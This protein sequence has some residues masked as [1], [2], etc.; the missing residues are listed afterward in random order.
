MKL[1]LCLADAY[2]E[3]NLKMKLFRNDRVFFDINRIL[4][5]NNWLQHMVCLH[6]NCAFWWQMHKNGNNLMVTRQPTING[7]KSSWSFYRQLNKEQENPMKWTYFKDS[8][9][10][11]QMAFYILQMDAIFFFLRLFIRRLCMILGLNTF[12][13]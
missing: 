7:R 4:D 1:L 6:L 10:T 11:F 9:I 12:N 13:E 2:N 5:D 3:T 8:T